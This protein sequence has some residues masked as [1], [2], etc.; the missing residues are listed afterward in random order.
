M[1]LICI[2]FLPSHLLSDRALPLASWLPLLPR[3]PTSPSPPLRPPLL[4]A[5]QSHS[6]ARPDRG[7]ARANPPRAERIDHAPPPSPSPPRLRW[8]PR[9]NTRTRLGSACPHC[10]RPLRRPPAREDPECPKPSRGREPASSSY[11][12]HVSAQ[13]KS[14]MIPTA[15]P[16]A[17]RYQLISDNC[18]SCF[19]LWAESIPTVRMHRFPG[20]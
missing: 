7:G 3:F 20:K 13:G 11:G 8:R 5:T 2:R 19:R 18:S 14:I 6:D 9:A 12:G 4:N 16:A 15:D 10:A 1:D 17:A